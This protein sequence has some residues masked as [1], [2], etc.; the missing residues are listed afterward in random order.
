M[1]RHLRHLVLIPVIIITVL[2]LLAFTPIYIKLE[3]SIYNAI[4]NLKKPI[5]Q[6]PDILLVDFGDEAI[7][8]AGTYPV[9]RAIYADGLYLLKELGAKTAVFD[10]EFI[11]P[12]PVGIDYN[13]LNKD[14]P[15]FLDSSF[16]VISKNTKDLFSA[17]ATGNL[18][19]SDAAYFLPD[20]ENLTN[21][22]KNEV[23]TKIQD[24]VRD[25]DVYLGNAAESFENCFFT[26]NINE[27][28][29]IENPEAY[30][31]FVD[32]FS[33]KNINIVSSNPALEYTGA[34]P[35][36][37]SIAKNSKG[38]GF[39]NVIIDSDGVRRKIDLI[40]VVNGVYF[41]QLAFSPLLNYLGNP[42]I[43]LYKNKI[44]LK[45]DKDTFQIPLNSDGSFNINW[46]PKTFEDSFKHLSFAELMSHDILY[47]KL[48][49]NLSNRKDWGYLNLYQGKT[50]LLEITNREDFI[51]EV[52][53]LLT[54]ENRDF[55]GSSLDQL[56]E[57]GMIAA[58]DYEIIKK[59]IPVWFNSNID[60]LSKILGLRE[61]I[62]SKALNSFAIIGNTATGTTDIGVNPFQK[63]YM[64]VGTHAS[65]VNTILNNQY[66]Y[67]S[68]RWLN[69]LIAL[70]FGL[71]LTMAI[72][73]LP[74]KRS[75]AVGTISIF[76]VN[77]VLIVIFRLTSFYIDP[78]MSS[79][80]I[81]TTFLIL[82]IS[83]FLSSE[84]EKS[85]INT[86]FSHY[87]SADVIKEIIAD[88]SKLNL[89]GEQKYMT[90]MF[91]DIRG[92]STFSEKLT[93]QE[94]VRLLN[95][96]LTEMSNTVIEHQGTID[97]YEGDAIISFYGAPVYFKEHA[98]NCC[99]SAVHMKRVEIELNKRFKEDAWIEDNIC[100]RI[101]INT[102]D[103]VVGNMGTQ[104]KMDY[105]IMGNSVNLAARLEG[106]NKLYG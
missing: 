25:N 3:G 72:Y 97:K 34:I 6:N 13:V 47:D 64:N 44:V 82:T 56:K 18:S 92:F 57:A 55:L 104:K 45:T 23:I 89:G 68:P 8:L 105:T 99:L 79:L 26:I 54:P 71:L 103:M 46:L 36:N 35:T 24:V 43:T 73:R 52:G 102:G 7:A 10:I 49:T 62:S 96:Y 14:I 69:A 53:T 33:L 98:Y 85:F 15:K 74:P 81:F 30:A 87:L 70:V 9:N 16:S 63:R 94:L 1:K 100:T 75:I 101:G 80:L 58:E 106:V 2:T 60:L 78:V 59:D 11:D 90:A 41:P 29:N 77:I 27:S 20:L 61:S 21:S 65:V 38:A 95:V 84:K 40:R 4:L 12:G 51:K 93:P 22:T 66:L 48:K 88:P 28:N 37:L 42:E 32:N 86:A 39:T 91:T 83:G 17:V 76:I 31:Y 67:T 19:I 5:S 50:P